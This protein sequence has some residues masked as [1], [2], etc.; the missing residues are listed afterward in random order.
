M[1]KRQKTATSNSLVFRELVQ[2]LAKNK[3]RSREDIA[4]AAERTSLSKTHIGQMVYQ[5][6]GG[7]DAWA[8]LLFDLYGLSP[9]QV[10]GLFHLAIKNLQKGTPI[11]ETKRNL[12]KVLIS[13]PEDKL[14][15]WLSLIT[16]AE[17]IKP[18]F[19]IKKNKK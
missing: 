18:T 15:F 7:M 5:G 14:W 19:T 16:A 11:S 17:G 12:E 9:N 10:E 6:K 13:L 3:L 2:K 8:E 1:S 4:N